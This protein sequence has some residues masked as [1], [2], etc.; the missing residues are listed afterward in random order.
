MPGFVPFHIAILLNVSITGALEA[1]SKWVGKTKIYS[2]GS[3]KRVGKGP[4]SIKIKQKSG[5]ARAHPTH[6]ALTP[7]YRG[8]GARETKGQL[9]YRYF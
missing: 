8:V 5:W 6:T 1:S 2:T 7:L 4:I 3:K 9:P